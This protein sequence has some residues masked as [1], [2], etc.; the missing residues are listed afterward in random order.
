MTLYRTDNRRGVFTAALVA[1]LATAGVSHAQTTIITREPAT[2]GTA[3]AVAPLEL[4]PVQR[5]RIYRTVVHERVAPAQGEV[6]YRVGTRVPSDV[7]LYAMPQS[8][9][10]DVPTLRPYKYMVVNGHVILVDPA[11]SQVVAELDD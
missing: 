5:H 7:D 1:L 8:V 11:T 4:T 6:V 2:T 9:V 10:V 3:V